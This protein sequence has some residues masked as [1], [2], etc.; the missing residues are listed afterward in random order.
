MCCFPVQD[1]IFVPGHYEQ[2]P[3]VLQPSS[4]ESKVYKA[5]CQFFLACTAISGVAFLLTVSP[6]L[7]ATSVVLGLI[8]LCLYCPDAIR[9]TFDVMYTSAKVFTILDRP[10]HY[11]YRRDYIRRPEVIVREVPVFVDRPI[12]RPRDRRNQQYEIPVDA[13]NVS[14][15]PQY[16]E[17][18][19]RDS[20]PRQAP[21]VQPQ[22]E[23]LDPQARHSVGGRNAESQDDLFARHRPE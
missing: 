6:E 11:S 20:A 7:C 5:V 2:N 23:P 10:T 14:P 19:V 4:S 21:V 22:P 8:T 15:T 3:H 9:A 12:E 13:F 17:R 1:R 18:H 16:Q